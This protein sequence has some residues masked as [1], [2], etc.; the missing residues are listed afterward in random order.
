MR[1]KVII[2]ALIS[3]I[4]LSV[5]CLMWHEGQKMD[6]GFQKRKESSMTRRDAGQGAVQETKRKAVQQEWAV[7]EDIQSAMGANLFQPG[8]Y[9]L[10]ERESLFV[11]GLY[12][13][14]GVAL[15][16]GKDVSEKEKYNIYCLKDDIW[17]VF[18]SH[19]PESVGN[20]I[21]ERHSNYDETSISNLVYHDGFLYYDV[22][23]D[24]NPGVGGEKM[25]FIYRIPVEGGEAEE[26]A[27]SYERFNLYNGKIYYVG[28][29]DVFWEMET[30]GTGRREI[31]RKSKNIY[32]R[33]FTVGGGCFYVENQG[34]ITGVNLETGDRKYY[35]DVGKD[36]DNLYYK[37]GYL[38]YDIKGSIYRMNVISGKKE[39]LAGANKAWLEGGYLYYIWQD[40][41]DWKWNLS[42]LDPETKQS[43]TEVLEG[44]KTS[45][46]FLQLVGEDLLVVIHVYD[47]YMYKV[48]KYIYYRYRSD[49]LQL[50][51]LY[52]Q[53]VLAENP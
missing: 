49:T 31:Y 12:L 27:L 32:H 23:Y 5:V 44:P 16:G 43:S 21:I 45:H 17:E 18:V 1:K 50:E 34:G 10:E 11:A 29:A 15:Y 13:D 42:V 48:E 4:C 2:F 6:G 39:E 30:D 53:E 37:D 36:L 25:M 3:A 8:C 9:L 52:R 19:P 14:A 24:D 35:K 47:E 33:L 22:L 26:L 41:V 28:A 20:E 38:Y 7:T 51:R 46:A 40:S